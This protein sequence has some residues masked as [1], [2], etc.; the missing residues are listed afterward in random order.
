MCGMLLLTMQSTLTTPSWMSTT[1]VWQDSM[2]Q[3]WQGSGRPRMPHWFGVWGSGL[4]TACV[5]QYQ[6]CRQAVLVYHGIVHVMNMFRPYT[7][8]ATAVMEAYF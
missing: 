1:H 5:M 4:R 2:V 3:S 7:W 8:S 6:A